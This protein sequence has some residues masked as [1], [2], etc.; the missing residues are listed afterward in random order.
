MQTNYNCQFKYFVPRIVKAKI[1]INHLHQRKGKKIVPVPLGGEKNGFQIMVTL[2][3]RDDLFMLKCETYGFPQGLF[4]IS[5]GKFYIHK[6][7]HIK[8]FWHS[9][10][11]E[12]KFVYNSITQP[13]NIRAFLQ[14]REKRKN[15][16][17]QLENS[18]GGQGHWTIQIPENTDNLLDYWRTNI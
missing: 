14:H 6:C 15:F 12:L 4:L 9:V 17:F 7:C 11:S 2:N 8:S 18:T 16:H 13:S 1:V 3:R 5:V 10:L